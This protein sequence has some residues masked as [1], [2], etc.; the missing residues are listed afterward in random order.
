MCFYVKP[1]LTSTAP[2]R[3]FYFW[4]R[5]RYDEFVSPS[6]TA[7]FFYF[8]VPKQAVWLAAA[9]LG[10]RVPFVACGFTC[11]KCGKFEVRFLPPI[12]Q[13]GPS[14]NTVILPPALYPRLLLSVHCHGRP[15]I[16]LLRPRDSRASGQT[17]PMVKVLTG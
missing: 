8:G 9:S 13:V 17:H 5:G 15:P 3:S 2:F 14:G 10:G 1:R 12:S 16:E 11:R 6:S 7:D 4:V